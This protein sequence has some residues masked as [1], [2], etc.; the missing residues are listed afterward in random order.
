M[1]SRSLVMQGRYEEA[2][3]VNVQMGNVLEM[4]TPDAK[5]LHSIV[6]LNIKAQ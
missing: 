5:V 1:K 4:A 6:M 2:D 3:A